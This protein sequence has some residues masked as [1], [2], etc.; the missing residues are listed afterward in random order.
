MTDEE[1]AAWL[2]SDRAKRVLLAELGVNTGGSETTRY[3]ANHAYTSASTDTPANQY[4]D[5]L[6]AGGISLQETLGLSSGAASMSQGDIRLNNADG[7]I[8]SWLSDAWSNRTIVIYLG[9]RGWPKADFRV[10]YSG[11]IASVE[12]SGQDYLLVRM[13]DKMQRLETAVTETKLGGSTPNADALIPLCFGECHN[14]TPLLTNAGTLE[15]AVHNGPIESIIEVR[16]NGVPVAYTPNL[17]TGRFTLAASPVGTITASVQGDKPSAYVNDVGSLVQRLVKD[18]GR[19][20]V[21]FTNADLDTANLSAFVTA[22]PQPVGLYLD[23]SITVREACNMLAASVGARTVMTRAGLLRLVKI[24][25]PPASTAYTITESD[26]VER[27]LHMAPRPRVSAA[28]KLGYCRNW[29]VQRDIQTG[30][31]PE[32]KELFAQEW[33]TVTSSDSTAATLHK[34]PLDVEQEDT[35]LLVTADAT[36]EANRRLALRSAARSVLSFTTGPKL[37]QCDLGSG[38]TLTSSRYGL[39]AGVAVQVVSL[40]IDWMHGSMHVEVLK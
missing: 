36:A 28:C 38:L 10:V 5:S 27:S 13:N 3:L 4:Y 26:T 22:N 34:L 11:T 2:E 32:H 31:L 8:D 40:D 37:I 6:L 17:A 30:I 7:G 20:D 24:A 14:V 15:Y 18:F 16:D 12:G 33:L 35:L 21:R 1:F 23:G 9:D 29:T 25:L 19:S 39:S